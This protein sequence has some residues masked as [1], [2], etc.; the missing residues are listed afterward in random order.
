MAI[1]A[2]RFKFLN[3]ETNTPIT[4]FLKITDSSSVNAAVSNIIVDGETSAV[5]TPSFS[6]EDTVKEGLLSI[7]TA[8]NTDGKV[9]EKLKELG[10]DLSEYVPKGMEM[11]VTGMAE[12]FKN[13]FNKISNLSSSSLCSLIN[14]ALGLSIVD[15][16]LNL[17]PD[18]RKRLFMMALLALMH[19]MCYTKFNDFDNVGNLINKSEIKDMSK[20]VFN[21]LIKPNSIPAVD[22]F[23]P[24][25]SN[26][27]MKAV[28]D[29]RKAPY[30]LPK[31]LNSTVN[32][33]LTAFA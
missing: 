21:N 18:M 25:G 14:A 32:P 8:L 28:N 6:L 9:T 7:K 4:D 22:K 29:I 11:G 5:S 30:A 27:I 23:L 15:M 3:Q 13:V 17:A 12:S 31:V 10:K 24:R 26:P 16:L 33:K 2:S 20:K 1:S 19:K